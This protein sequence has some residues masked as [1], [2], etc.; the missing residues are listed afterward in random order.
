MAL[1]KVSK[2]D[3]TA[4]DLESK[5]QTIATIWGQFEAKRASGNL[6][7]QDSLAIVLTFLSSM[8]AASEFLGSGLKL[9][10][11]LEYLKNNDLAGLL[12]GINSLESLVEDKEPTVEP[13]EK[14]AEEG[15]EENSSDSD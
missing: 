11:I 15:A 14:A 7:K 2:P 9:E 1:V 4:E 6:N 10:N 13:A 5:K 3:L 8:P 12:V